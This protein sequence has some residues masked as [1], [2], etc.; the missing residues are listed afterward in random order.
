MTDPV[1][2]GTQQEVTERRSAA[3]T[4]ADDEA[5]RSDEERVGWAR[6]LVRPAATTIL[7]F[8]GFLA[9]WWLL[10]TFFFNPRLIPPPQEVVFGGLDL[11]I[12]G[13]LI[14]DI[15]ASL[16]RVVVGLA[17]G[18]VA[19]IALGLLTGRLRTVKELVDP[20]VQLLRNL[21]PTAMIPLAIVWFGIGEASKYFL[22]FWGT[23]FILAVNTTAG[24]HSTPRTRIRAAQCLGASEAVVFRRIILPSSL[25]YV[26]AGVRL[27]VAS[28]YMTIIPAE[29]IAAQSGLGALLQE[30][31]LMGQV[32]RIFVALGVIAIL[33][34]ATDRLVRFIGDN[35]LGSYTQY[36]ARL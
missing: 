18:T 36:L 25:P 29:I 34:Y 12:G 15:V 23:F 6:R 30:A 19:G 21:S 3:A 16:K 31:S 26:F 14:T 32:D 9:T 17:I 22:I 24:V 28:G 11:A 33:G 8:G 2:T 4:L 5:S 35:V 10:S 13:D 27:A 20:V 7:S 1:E